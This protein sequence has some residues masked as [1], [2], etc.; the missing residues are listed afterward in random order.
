VVDAEQARVRTAR[1]EESLRVSTHADR[2]VYH[3]APVPGAQEKRH[4]VDEDREVRSL[5]L[6]T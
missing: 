2:P 3:P 6:H 4:F 1:L 5:P